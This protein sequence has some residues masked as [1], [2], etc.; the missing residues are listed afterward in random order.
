M[1]G[2]MLPGNFPYGGKMMY[3]SDVASSRHDV[4]SDCFVISYMGSDQKF[5]ARDAACDS[6]QFQYAVRVW[7]DAVH[8]SHQSKGPSNVSG[9]SNQNAASSPAGA[10][11]G[12]G[13]VGG[14]LNSK[15]FQ[16]QILAAAQ[17]T[18]QAA[19]QLAMY[20]ATFTGSGGGGGQY[21]PTQAGLGGGGWLGDQERYVRPEPLTD[22]GIKLGEIIGW[23][24]WRLTFEGFLHSMSADV[25]WAPGEPMHGNV[26]AWTDHNGVYAYKHARDFLKKHSS[27]LAVYGKVA[28]W[29]R[30][31][32][33]ELGYRAEWAK[34]IHLEEVLHKR[35]PLIS[36]AE[37]RNRYGVTA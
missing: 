25:L 26:K 1:S 5:D 17:A 31:I 35:P 19:S 36:L 18:N 2:N 20:Q 11:S 6:K 4:G 30:V 12:G 34:I 15:Q 32:E 3:R 8:S 33:H 7:L 22:G 9:Q 13:G 10:Q 24:G 21:I 23:R 27:G 14:Q 29:G 16:Q 37:L 28:M